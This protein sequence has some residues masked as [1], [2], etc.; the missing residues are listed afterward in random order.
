[1]TDVKILHQVEG[2]PIFQNRMYPSREAARSCIKGDVVLVEDL[3]SGLVYN[4][5]FRP[6]VMNYDSNYQNEQGNSPRFQDHLT[7]IAELIEKRMGL[8]GLVEVG[9]GKGLFLE[10]L[11]TRGAQ[12]TGYDP[13][14]EGANPK[15]VREYFSKS[16]G[17]TGKGLILRHVLEHIQDPVSFLF[18]LQEA[19]GGSGEIYIE[20]PCFDWICAHRTWFDVFYEHVNYFRLSD[21]SRMFG[22]VH[23]AKHTFGGQY[24]S[25]VA[26]LATLRRPQFDPNDRP[27]FPADFSATMQP[28]SLANSVVWGGA[29]KGVLFC[30]MMERAGVTVDHVV[31]INPAKQ[32]KFLP[33]TGLEVKSA[34]HVLPTLADGAT[35]YVMNSNYLSEIR[36]MSGN[37]FRYVTIDQIPLPA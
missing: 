5:A 14:Y 12:I 24:L 34:E 21:F 8:N 29:S 6:D 30:L 19:N 1:M 37:N 17:I 10:L 31:D 32:G 16:L 20:V 15:I 28:R 2:L 13:T 4:Q 23:E 33:A 7:S 35:I 27:Q 26:D 11:A 22:V 9:C 36:E 18:D 25:V 3:N